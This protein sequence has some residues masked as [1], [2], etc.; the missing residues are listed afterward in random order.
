MSR[1]KLTGGAAAACCARAAR[2][3]AL[4]RATAKPEAATT[5]AQRAR[6][7]RMRDILVAD[8]GLPRIVQTLT[9]WNEPRLTVR[10]EPPVYREPAPPAALFSRRS[11]RPASAFALGRPALRRG[12]PCLSA[13]RKVH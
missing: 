7:T 9:A 5:T 6:V 4:P 11:A 12:R 2:F 3:D 13:R 8:W 1:L 10:P